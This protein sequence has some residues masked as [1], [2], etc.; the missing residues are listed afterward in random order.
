MIVKY[1]NEAL[2][3]LRN[4]T[5]IKEIPENENPKNVAN[6]VEKIIEFNK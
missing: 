5:N 4:N 3:D 6:I 1:L 2:I